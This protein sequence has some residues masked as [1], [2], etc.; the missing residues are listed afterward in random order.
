MFSFLLSVYLGME[1]LP[2]V[3]SLFN[4]LR[5]CWAVFQSVDGFQFLHILTNTCYCRL[6]YKCPSECEVVSHCA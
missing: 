6:N 2:H 5:N 1:L 3:A 4:R